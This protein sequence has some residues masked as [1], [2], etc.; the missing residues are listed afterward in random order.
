MQLEALQLLRNQRQFG[1]E[2]EAVHEWIGTAIGDRRTFRLRIASTGDVRS[3][4]TF[5][6]E[7]AVAYWSL[8]KGTS[9]MT[10]RFPALRL[11]DPLVRLDT[12]SSDWEVLEKVAAKSA[13]ASVTA[14]VV[15]MLNDYC[16]KGAKNPI[17]VWDA[18]DTW[19][20]PILTWTSGTQDA[21]LLQ[22][23]AAAR[24][25]G[26]FAGI[27][28]SPKDADAQGV[29]CESA[30]AVTTKLLA[31]AQHALAKTSDRDQLEALVHLIVGKRVRGKNGKH[32]IKSVQ[33]CV[34]IAEP[35]DPFATIYS[36]QVRHALSLVLPRSDEVGTCSLTGDPGALLTTKFAPWFGKTP[37]YSKNPDSKCNAR[38]G[39]DGLDGF[40]V[41]EEVARVL[42]GGLKQMTSATREGKTWSRIQNGKG[43]RDPRTGRWKEATDWLLAYPSFP[44][45]EL[46]TIDAFCRSESASDVEATQ[47]MKQFE[48]ASETLCARL[49]Q[50]APA[51]Q[52]IPAYLQ[53]LIVRQVS[54]G[55]LQL[56]FADDTPI[57]RLADALAAWRTSNLPRSLRLP[58]P[59]GKGPSQ[60]AWVKPRVLFPEQVVQLL[61]HQWTREGAT[62]TRLEAP[63]VGLVFELLLRKPGVWQDH[64]LR[65]LDTTLARFG[66]LL[67]GL[68]RLL[69]LN[70][71]VEGEADDKWRAKWLEQFPTTHA[72]KTDFTKP[73]PGRAFLNSVSLI[74]SLLNAMNS[75]VDHYTNESA[76]LMGKL[77]AIM[78]ELHRCYCIAQRDGDIPNALIGNGLLGRA[79]EA[80]A[81][82]LEELL[83]R[84]RIYLGWAKTAE[85][86][87]GEDK[88]AS[89]IAV[90][91]ARKVVRLAAP[92]SE[93]L[94]RADALEHEL[95]SE[96]KAHLFLGY[97]SPILGTDADA[98]E[99]S[100]T[101]EDDQPKGKN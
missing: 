36:A 71:R 76:F 12:E 79:A 23:C 6:K 28:D 97:L 8:A 77:L 83:D 1:Y 92:L 5:E 14:R 96:R 18:W 73:Q 30:L 11:A 66:P 56:V 42:T 13:D 38:Y 90:F 101:P 68:G 54:D 70:P 41:L 9:A 55:Q 2:R 20:G 99:N 98:A 7:D 89:R 19:A 88:K 60:L 67:T 87:S 59:G 82:A 50:Q 91:S 95:S 75:T 51:V 27:S 81:R 21:H 61:T 48:D 53:V 62:S 26:A 80:P 17:D 34:D 78:D 4:S 58:V 40:P 86:P 84:S 32:A 100:D 29:R 3:L 69:H 85:V 57:D 45:A 65:L 46:R 10:K 16:A 63:P 15:A 35:T 47:R 94:H 49:R 39:R 52:E 25:F 24:A 37:V 31:V 22:L 44:V 72:G 74:G 64:A 33:I 43:Q 93:S